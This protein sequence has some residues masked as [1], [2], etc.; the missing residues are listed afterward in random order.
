MEKSPLSKEQVM[1]LADMPFVC[2]GCGGQRHRLERQRGT[3]Y[4]HRCLDCKK[5][6]PAKPTLTS[7]G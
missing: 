3:G 7:L 1:A 2:E 4:I 5:P 6:K